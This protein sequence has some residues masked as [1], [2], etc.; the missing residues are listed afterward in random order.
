MK[1][2]TVITAILLILSFLHAYGQNNYASNVKTTVSGEQKLFIHYDIVVNDDAKFFKVNLDFI[3]EGKKLE[4]NPNNIYG[5]YGHAMTPGNKIIYWN[6][7][8]DFKGDINKVKVTVFAFREQEPKAMFKKGSVGNDSYA[9]CEIVFVN[10]SENADRYEWDFG[11]PS[12]GIENKSFEEDP[13]HTFKKGGSHTIALTAINTKLDLR[14]TFYETIIIKEHSPTKADFMV[15]GYNREVPVT[16]KFENNSVNADSYSWN[17]GDPGSGKYNNVSVLENPEHKYVND[18]KYLV[19]LTVSNSVSG[20]SDKMSK[21]VILI[22]PIRKVKTPKEVKPTVSKSA[23][24]KH[25]TNKNIW[26]T[27]GIASFGTGVYTMLNS[28]KLRDDY[29]TATTDAADIRSKIDANEAITPI[30][31]GASALCAVQVYIQAKKQAKADKKVSFNLVPTSDGGQLCI[32]YTI[33]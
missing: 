17:F 28:N 29:K 33:K 14:H 4:T 32:T 22:Q 25:K 30:A 9:P 5:D 7:S 15:V 2:R 1:S 27:A 12:S 20:F 6:Y 13:V 18:G 8:D 3:Y 21:E 24:L 11:D 19:E 16:I 10:H 26:L 31:F 23:Y